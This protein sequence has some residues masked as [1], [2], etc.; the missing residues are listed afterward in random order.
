MPRLTT[1]SNPT[2][3]IDID[4]R[5]VDIA[6]FDDADGPACSLTRLDLSDLPIGEAT[7]VVLI[8]R[9]GNSEARFELGSTS[10]WDKRPKSLSSL[11]HDGAFTFRLLVVRAGFPKL[12]A[13]AEDIRPEGE[14]ESSSLVALLPADLGE[15]PWRISIREL[16]GRVIL[17]FNKK[18]FQSSTE[19]EADLFFIRLVLPQVFRCLAEWVTRNASAIEDPPWNELAAILLHLGVDLENIPTDDTAEREDWVSHVVTAFCDKFE[20]AS[21]LGRFRNKG[22]DE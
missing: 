9:R 1:L 22:E 14:G 12:V 20:F 11:N 21:E 8:A 17:E 3:L 18:I 4:K 7:S 6:R 10:D 19:A 5:R 16:E 15:L 2:G 13:A